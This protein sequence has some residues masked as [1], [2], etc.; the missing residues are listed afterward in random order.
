MGK[1]L[2]GCRWRTPGHA[3]PLSPSKGKGWRKGET[4]IPVLYSLLVAFFLSGPAYGAVFTDEV[5]RRVEIKPSPQRIISLAPSLTEALFALGLGER[6]AGVTTFC[7]YPPEALRKEKVGGYV[8][9]SLERVVA[10]KPDLV[11][12]PAEG[13]LRSFVG[14]LTRLGTAVYIIN[15]RSVS[16]VLRS[17]RNIG[18]VTS[19]SSRA[20]EVVAAM[21]KKMQAVRE[22]TNGLPRPRVLHV[23]AHNPLISSGKD[24]FVGDLIRLAGGTNIA[25]SAGGKHPHLSMEEVIAQNPEVILLSSMKSEQAG[26]KEWWRRWREISAVRS[27]RIYTMDSDLILRSS[28]RIVD[29]LVDVAKALHPKAFQIE[30][31]KVQNAK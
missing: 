6:I 4:C 28:P 18:D 23:L 30:N 10:L 22:K 15:P 3:P 29:G 12:G 17:I 2:S 24:T 9:P 20:V 16:D 13:E 8:T 1:H 5:G 7:N 25:E 14:E 26:H 19:A 11:I 31:F 27:N 21:Q